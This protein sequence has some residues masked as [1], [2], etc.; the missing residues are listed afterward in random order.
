MLTDE[1]LVEE[2]EIKEDEPWYDHQDL[3]QDL[4]LAAELGKTLLDRNTELEEAL[5]QMYTT[6]EEQLQEIE[7]LT[8][9]VEL[10][11]QMN[12][13]HTK[14][15]E[16]LDM[17]ARELEKANRKL[18]TESKGY[19]Q[20]VLRLTETIESLQVHVDSLQR[21]VE[22]LKK[23][24][25]GCV[26]REKSEPRRSMH[27]FT[28]LK[29]LY[30]LRKY[31]VY[32]HVFAEKITSIQSP[33]SPLEEENS[34]LKK[35]LTVLQAQLNIEKERRANIEQEYTIILKENKELEERLT[36]L[37]CYRA[38]VKEL[39]AEVVEMRQACQSDSLFV[40]RVEQ[41]VPESFLI[42]FRESCERDTAQSPPAE[43]TVLMYIPESNKSR[44]KRSSSESFLQSATTEEILNGHEETCIRR[45]EAVKRRGVSL[46]NEVDAQ[47][48]A[49]QAKYEEL[50]KRCQ[51]SEDSPNHK[52]VQTLRRHSRDLSGTKFQA[53]EVACSSQES[54]NRELSSCTSRLSLLDLGS[55]NAS[56]PEYKVLFKEIF[57]CIKKTKEE[58]DEH[59]TKYKHVT[60]EAK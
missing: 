42:S 3:E 51:S 46:L 37:D 18:V 4:H 19:Q 47:Y 16:Q 38:Q 57:S 8:K 39:E 52:A 12:E 23:S 20:K 27:S 9:Q 40:N 24:G 56:Q 1:S 50:L 2:F 34:E 11:R 14:V 25:Q 13:Q 58:I 53:D 22:E 10:L 5:Q 49:L 43:E 7:Y 30:D 26:T 15:H 21:Q 41:L 36:D 17:T 28:C 35:T 59:R 48:S 54:F 6:N 33:M 45:A 32:D 29:E 31:F 44:L 60:S 55:T